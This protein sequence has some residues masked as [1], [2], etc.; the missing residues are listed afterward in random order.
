MML[1]AGPKESPL[2]DVSLEDVGMQGQ[3]E[4]PCRQGETIEDC[5][6]VGPILIYMGR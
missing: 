1:F 4:E 3:L 5:N 6:Q 2:E